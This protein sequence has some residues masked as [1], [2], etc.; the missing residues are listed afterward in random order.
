MENTATQNIEHFVNGI[1]V[2]ILGETVQAVKD[3][4]SLGECQFRAKNTWIGGSK[5]MTSVQD[6]YGAGQEMEHKQTFVF[7]AD[8]PPVLAGF[9][10]AANP[11][12]YLLHALAACVTTSMVAHAAVRGIEIDEMSSTLE[13]D[14]N[15]NGFL[16]IDPS[17]QKGF[18]EIRVKF[19]VKGNADAEQ[20]KQL[21][22]F[23]P[24][25]KTITEGANVVI[26]VDKT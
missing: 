17:L 3:D 20:F 18:S 5:N 21:A 6:Y 2:S 16:G 1:D 25:Y 13:G 14:I 11:V 4:A 24:V 15:L 22:E 19:E 10:D 7:Q 8:E 23:S 26:S 9:D 12:E